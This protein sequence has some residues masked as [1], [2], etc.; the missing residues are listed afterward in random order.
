MKR[1]EKLPC[2]SVPNLRLRSVAARPSE[3]KRAARGADPQRGALHVWVPGIR[4][5]WLT[6]LIGPQVLASRTCGQQA[7]GTRAVGTGAAQEAAG[8]VLEGGAEEEEEVHPFQSPR[9]QISQ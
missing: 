3:R 1:V 8:S 2:A 9:N 5:A 4:T 7:A 6:S